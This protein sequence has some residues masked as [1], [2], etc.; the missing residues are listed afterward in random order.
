MRKSE[1]CSTASLA[2][3]RPQME[4]CKPLLCVQVL[5]LFSLLRCTCVQAV[6]DSASA[7][8][9]C[10]LGKHVRPIVYTPGFGGS[11]LFNYSD[12][13]TT[14]YPSGADLFGSGFEPANNLALP[15]R[16][17]ASGAQKASEAGPK[18]SPSDKLPGTEGLARTFISAVRFPSSSFLFVILWRAVC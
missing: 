1:F 2:T 13:Y 3:S 8:D 9:N 4:G 12:G 7:R 18:S 10:Q 14:A 15:L 16:W 17:D 6:T 5:L 11:V